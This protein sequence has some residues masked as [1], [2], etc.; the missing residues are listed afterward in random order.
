MML[1]VTGGTGG[2]LR[3]SIIALLTVIG[4]STSASND[5]LSHAIYT[6]LCTICTTSCAEVKVV[7][8]SHN[9]YA[10]SSTVSQIKRTTGPKF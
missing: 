6:V 1:G 8:L 3:G 9:S 7:E 4:E 10:L 5:C 2:G